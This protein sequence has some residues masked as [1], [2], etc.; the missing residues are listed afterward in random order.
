MVAFSSEEKV[1]MSSSPNLTDRQRYWLEHIRACEQSGQSL[2]G[3][4]AEHDLDIGALYEAKSKL[5]RKGLVSP[6]DNQARFVR[7][8]PS[9]VAASMPPVCRVHLRNGTVM[10]LPCSPE[11]WEVLLGVAAQLP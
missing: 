6:A 8:E 10:E 11:H 9:R 7:V 5:K 4:A 3:Y 2:K 1:M